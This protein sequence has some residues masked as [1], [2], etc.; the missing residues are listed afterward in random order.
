MH[1]SET[2]HLVETADPVALPFNTPGREILMLPRVDGE[3]R[4][5]VNAGSVTVYGSV[6]DIG[7]SGAVRVN[8]EAELFG[9]RAPIASAFITPG[10]PPAA[11]ITASGIV[12]DSWH[13]RAQSTNNRFRLHA[14]LASLK[15]CAEP[16]VRVNKAHQSPPL[17][18]GDFGQRGTDNFIAPPIVPWGRENGLYVP[19][20]D[21][22]PGAGPTVFTALPGS[23]LKRVFTLGGAVGNLLTITDTVGNVFYSD[24]VPIGV[25]YELLP[26]GDVEI[27]TIAYTDMD[28]ILIEVVR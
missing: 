2:V 4:R 8:L 24:D 10:Q 26:D 19:F 11:L 12:A 21:A 1:E 20:S 5:S 6:K 16:K 15:C 28:Y 22:N 3:R 13:V 27:A 17:A 7:L 14:T 9:E 23:R 25:P 18:I